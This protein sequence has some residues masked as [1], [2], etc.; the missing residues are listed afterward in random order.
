ML[1]G[2]AMRSAMRL[3][4]PVV[5]AAIAVTTTLL[6]LWAGRFAD[7]YV[8]LPVPLATAAPAMLVGGA[9]FGFYSWALLG[10]EGG[11]Q[12]TIWDHLRRC[13]MLYPFVAFL[14]LFMIFY[15]V[16]ADPGGGGAIVAMVF[17]AAGYTVLVDALAQFVVRRR[18]HRASLRGGV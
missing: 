7:H 8:G 3:V 9:V 4:S 15:S 5:Y 12:L 18:S 14:G 1:A 11:D 10:L 6:V 13:A 16:W 2:R 17:I